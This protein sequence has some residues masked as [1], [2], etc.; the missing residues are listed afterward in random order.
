MKYGVDGEIADV[1]R[2]ALRCV[3]NALL[4]NPNMGQVFVDT[5]Y[6]SRLAEGLKVCYRI[7]MVSI[8]MLI[9]GVSVMHQM[10]K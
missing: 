2:S 9:L 4:L 3:A 8:M 6:A 1:R 7:S 10:M 5:G